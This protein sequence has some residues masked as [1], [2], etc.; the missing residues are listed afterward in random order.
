MNTASAGFS[1]ASGGD[2]SGAPVPFGLFYKTVDVL[3]HDFHGDWS[4]SLVDKH[5]CKALPP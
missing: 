4:S 5:Q 3:I 1:K 2:Q